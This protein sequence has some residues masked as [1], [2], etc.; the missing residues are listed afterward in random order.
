M[1]ITQKERLQLHQEDNRRLSRFF[2]ALPTEA[3]LQATLFTRPALFFICY[4]F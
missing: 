4:I 3:V 2:D 1:D